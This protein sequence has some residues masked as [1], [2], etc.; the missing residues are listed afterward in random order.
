M[1]SLLE[2]SFR[3]LI[4]KTDVFFFSALIYHRHT[5]TA[6]ERAHCPLKHKPNFIVFVS[7]IYFCPFIMMLLGWS[8]TPQAA[9][10]RY[11]CT[12]SFDS[13]KV[14][15]HETFATV[16]INA[17]LLFFS[18]GDYLNCSAL[19]TEHRKHNWFINPALILASNVVWIRIDSSCLGHNIICYRKQMWPLCCRR[20]LRLCHSVHRWFVLGLACRTKQLLRYHWASLIAS[21]QLPWIIRN[22]NFNNSS[23]CY[24][25]KSM[26]STK[27][28]MS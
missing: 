7:F 16:L 13:I 17:P 27:T 2:S 22:N 12:C 24:G 3:S 26:K 18:V 5:S 6:V 11:M 10:A 8:Q 23:V 20:Q 19:I 25:L 15:D 1:R 14:S 28:G 4:I 9:D 21:R